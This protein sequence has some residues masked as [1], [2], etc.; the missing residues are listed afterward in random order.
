MWGV[1][2]QPVAW[3]KYDVLHSGYYGLLGLYVHMTN[4][5]PCLCVNIVGSLGGH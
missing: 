2:R 4:R 1:L 5:Q 3:V